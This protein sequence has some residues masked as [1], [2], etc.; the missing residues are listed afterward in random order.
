M[1]SI[2]RTEGFEEH[3]EKT[4]VMRRGRRQEVT[5]VAVNTKLSVPRDE[6]RTLRAILHNA[7]KHG[8]QSQNRENVANFVAHLRG[9]IAWVHSV[10]PARA[11]KLYAALEKVRG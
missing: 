1:R 5:G 8:L 10:D 6:W 4:R 3:P 9:R 7:A 2:V 11:V